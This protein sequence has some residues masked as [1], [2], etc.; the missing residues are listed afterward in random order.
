[1][2]TI[3]DFLNS[4]KL[5]NNLTSIEKA[6]LMPMCMLHII[7]EGAF[8]TPPSTSERSIYYIVSGTAT[9][10]GREQHHMLHQFVGIEALSNVCALTCMTIIQIPLHCL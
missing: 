10:S 2:Q 6:S 9:R 4:H 5:F 7:P 1:M 3:V 8:F